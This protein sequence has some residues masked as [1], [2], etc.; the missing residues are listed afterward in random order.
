MLVKPALPDD[1]IIACLEKEY[2]FHVYGI[3]FLPLGADLNTVVYRAESVKA[4]SLFVKLR[5]SNFKEISVLLPKALADHGIQHIIAP[6]PN[7]EGRLWISL[8]KYRL[9]LYPFFE[10]RDG[11]EVELTDEQWID[12]GATMKMIHSLKLPESIAGCI[13]EEKF[14]GIWRNRLLSLMRRVETSSSNDPLIRSL[15]KVIKE[16]REI[17]IGIIKRTKNLALMCKGR[18]LEH[19]LCHADIHA[20]NL[21]IGANNDFHIVDWDDPI[22][23]PRERDLM[24]IGGGIAGKWKNQREIDLFYRGYGRVKIDSEILEYY[25]LARIIEDLAIE[26]RLILSIKK[27]L[28]DR[29]QSYRFLLSIF[30]PGGEIEMADS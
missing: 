6:F 22:L 19:V 8:G 24:F 27:N 11:Y 18:N 3:E 16:K 30:A 14:S 26:C 4:G 12:F 21:L 28:E 10:G 7:R 2:G 17:I 29:E 15:V 25:R 1:R 20:G 5:A 9:T 13:P 23:A